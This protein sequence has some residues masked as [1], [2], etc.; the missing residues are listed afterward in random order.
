L[1]DYDIIKQTIIYAGVTMS[2][3]QT[4]EEQ[5]LQTYQENLLF[6]QQTQPKLF[7]KINAFNLALEKGYYQEKYSLE[8]KDEG[9]FDVLEIATGKYLYGSDSKKYAQLAAKSIDFT[10]KDNLFETFYNLSFDEVDEQDL[11]TKDVIKYSYSTVASLVNY[12]NTYASKENTTMIKLYKFIF[13]GLGLG[14]HT[15]EIDKKLHSNV[16]LLIEDDLE[17]FHLSMFVT[18]YKTLTDNGAELFFSIFEEPAE[19]KNTVQAF[20]Y[21]QFIYNHYIKFFHMLHHK[22][23]RIKDIQNI[24]VTQTYLTF[25]YAALMTSLLRPLEYIRNG[26]KILNLEASY[27]NTP[28]REKPLLIIGAGPSFDQNIEWLKNNHQKFI[29][30]IVSALMAKFEELSIKPDIITHVHGFEDAMP[31]IQKVKDLSFFDTT[32]GLFGGMSYPDFT[33]KFKQ[34]NIYILEGSSRYKDG[35]SG[36]TSSNIGSLSYGLFL[37]LQAKDIYLLGLDFATNQK[38]GQ[39]HADIHAHTRNVDLTINEEV[40]GGVEAKNEIIQVEGN[41]QEKVYTSVLFDAMRRECNALAKTYETK[42]SHS[43][44]L[45]NGAKIETAQPLKP[46]DIQIKE[47]IDKKKL[48]KEL[49]KTFDARSEN[50][51]TEKELEDIQK[52]LEYYDSV[53]KVLENHLTLPKGDINQYHYNLLGTFYNLLTEDY[54]NKHTSDM[55]YIITLYLQFVSGYI[56]DLINTKEIKNRKKLIKQLDKVIIPQIIRVIKYFR[57]TMES[58]LQEIKK[59]E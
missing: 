10:K 49:R 12:S 16:Y 46:Q 15:I 19:F 26:Y 8:Y 17:L 54:A 6:F 34:E 9:Y 37:Y 53:I 48:Y 50:F 14:N 57:D 59:G 22:E 5:A 20:L 43:F 23:Q 25:N 27:E 2:N 24:I 28:L 58:L 13:I 1:I 29:V 44:N 36:I 11:K 39:T 42:N 38:T 3:T 33:T 32:I 30:V 47:R 56:F 4:I 45:S 21:A 52:R 18:N 55:N 31:H 7:E 51:L 35:F 40:G 41:F